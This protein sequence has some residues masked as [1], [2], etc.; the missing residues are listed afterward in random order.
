VS[1]FHFE[2]ESYLDLMREEL[3]RYEELQEQTAA[4]SRGF[5]VREALE[6]GTGTGETARR[7]LA[8]HPDA[9]LTG[10]DASTQMLE[11]ARE[12]LP[13]GRVRELRAAQLQD[14][15]PEGPFDLVFTTLAVHHLDAGEKQDLFRRVAAVLHPWGRFVLADVV[16]PSDPADAVTPLSPDFDRP[17]RLEDQLGWLRDAGFEPRVAWSWKDVAVVQ[18]SSVKLSRSRG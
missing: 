5:E 7:V 10:V 2:P 17:D 18:A 8:L 15:L 3:P 6:L 4:A 13:E 16:V 9:R 14:P 12:T 1:Q 11:R